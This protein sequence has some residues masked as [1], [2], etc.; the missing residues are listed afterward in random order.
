MV[1]VEQPNL[2]GLNVFEE[3]GHR[4]VRVDTNANRNCVDEQPENVFD[5]GQRR[6]ST[7]DGGSEHDVVASE[8]STEQ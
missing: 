2:L 1:T 4:T 5:P 6:G 7:R 3:F 8:H